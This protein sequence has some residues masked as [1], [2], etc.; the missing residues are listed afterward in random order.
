LRG[1]KNIN[2][3]TYKHPWNCLSYSNNLYVEISEECLAKKIEIL[4]FYKSQKKRFYFN[5]EYIKALAR[6]NG[7][8]AGY[9]YAEAF[10]VVRKFRF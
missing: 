4:A 1:F 5:P 2:L 9:K 8:M 6:F 7:G 3:V 10:D